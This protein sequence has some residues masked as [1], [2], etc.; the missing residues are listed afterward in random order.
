MALCRAV[1]DY[2]KEGGATNNQIDEFLD[3]CSMFQ[4]MKKLHGT[5]VTAFGQDYFIIAELHSGRHDRFDFAKCLKEYLRIFQS[6]L[7]HCTFHFIEIRPIFVHI[8]IPDWNFLTKFCSSDLSFNRNILKSLYLKSETSAHAQL[9]NYSF[10]H[11]VY[12]FHGIVQLETYI[13]NGVNVMI[14]VT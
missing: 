11:T 14:V 7:N 1:N 4:K 12:K 5:S 8:F 13:D 9:C 2:L 3:F 10:I 6:M